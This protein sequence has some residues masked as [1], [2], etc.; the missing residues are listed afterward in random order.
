MPANADQNGHGPADVQMVMI[1]MGGEPSDIVVP[2]GV[3]VTMLGNLLDRDDVLFTV[4]LG[5]AMTSV[6]LAK[7]RHRRDRPEMAGAAPEDSG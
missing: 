7:V 6:R 2:V 3:A 5:E 1:P 4:L